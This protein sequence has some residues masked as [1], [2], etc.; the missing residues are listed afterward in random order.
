MFYESQRIVDK[1]LKLVKSRAY[2]IINSLESEKLTHD[3]VL[4]CINLMM[5]GDNTETQIDVLNYARQ[6]VLA[7]QEIERVEDNTSV[8][9]DA[10]DGLEHIIQDRKTKE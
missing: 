6:V 1:H 4:S 9:N 2:G 5:I 3:E 7:K 10:N 8:N